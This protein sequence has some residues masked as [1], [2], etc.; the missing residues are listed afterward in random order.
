MSVDPSETIINFFGSLYM[1][2]VYFGVIGL[3]FWGLSEWIFGSENTN[4]VLSNKEMVG[5]IIN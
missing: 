3:L 5:P 1:V 2:V 4:T